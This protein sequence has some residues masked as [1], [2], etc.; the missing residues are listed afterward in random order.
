[1]T[2]HHGRGQLIVDKIV[3]CLYK[4]N[5]DACF[6]DLCCML[7]K[8]PTVNSNGSFFSE[9]A[10]STFS[11]S[12]VTQLCSSNVKRRFPDKEKKKVGCR[13]ALVLISPSFATVHNVLRS[14]LEGRGR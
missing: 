2:S 11:P 1:M 5:L 7:M 12:L 4:G 13:G 14:I 8:T 6:K 3:K 10:N 9:I